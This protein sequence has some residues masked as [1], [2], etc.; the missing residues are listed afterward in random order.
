MKHLASFIC[1][2]FIFSNITAFAQIEKL[3]K[4]QDKL[5]NTKIHDIYQDN[6]GFIWISTENGLS[7][8]DG[9]NFH[10][11]KHEENNPNSI[12]SN[13]VLSATEDSEGNMWVGTRDGLQILEV[14]YN[15]FSTFPLQ[16]IDPSGNSHYSICEMI[17]TKLPDEK[18]ELIVSSR[19]NGL[20]IIDIKELKINKEKQETIND[21]LKSKRIQK[22]LLD[23]KQRLWISYA[24]G[25]LNVCDAVSGLI[26][27]VIENK[28]PKTETVFSYI[29]E[30]PISGN[31]IFSTFDQGLFVYEEKSRTFRAFKDKRLMNY[32]ILTLLYGELPYIN[33][34]RTMIIGTDNYGFK[35]VDL[36]SEELIDIPLSKSRHHTSHWKVSSLLM[37]KQENIWAGAYQTGLFL[38]PKPMYNFE[39]ACFNS[40][41]IEGENSSCITSIIED[42]E[43]EVLWIGSDGSGLFKMDRSAYY[44]VF[45]KENSNL[46]DNSIMSL[47]IDKRGDLWIASFHG[48][49]SKRVNDN[50][51]KKL[52]LDGKIE[53]VQLTSLQYDSSRDLM[54]V[55]TNGHGLIILDAEKEEVIR[56]ISDKINK[57]IGS[58]TLAEDNSVWIGTANGL[59]NYFYD[60]DE[61]YRHSISNNEKEEKINTVKSRRNGNILVGTDYGLIEYTPQNKNRHDITDGNS[62][63]DISVMGILESNDEII[64]LSTQDGLVKYNPADSSYFNYSLADGLQ[65]NQF[66]LNAAYKGDNGIMYFGGVGGLSFFNQNLDNNYHH[67]LP[68]IYF[69]ELY[70]NGS[71]INYDSHIDSKILDKHI[72]EATIINLPYA[73]NS[74][75][76]RYTVPEFT[77]PTRI[78]YS[79]RLLGA[80]GKWINSG[81]SRS[82]TFAKLPAGQ[83]TLQIRANLYGNESNYTQRD[84]LIKIAPPAYLSVWAFL[85]YIIIIAILSLLIYDI[86]KVGKNRKSKRLQ[87]EL[88][89]QKVKL[90][91]E[92]SYEIKTPLSIAIKELEKIKTESDSKTINKAYKE[93]YKNSIRAKQALGQILN[94]NKEMQNETPNFQETE[95]NGFI[96][97]IIK[98]FDNIAEARNIKLEL[99][100]SNDAINVW[101]DHDILDSIIFYMIN[102]AFEQI[103]DESRISIDISE[104][105]HNNG[106]LNRNVNKYIKINF[107]CHDI[108]YEESFFNKILEQMYESDLQDDEPKESARF[109]IIRKS[110]ER[111]HGRMWAEN[112]PEDGLVFIIFIPIG[113]NHLNLG[114]IDSDSK[115]ITEIKPIASANKDNNEDN[116]VADYDLRKLKEDYLNEKKLM[117]FTGADGVF[118]RK[119]YNYII[120]NIANPSLSVEDLGKHIGISRVHLNRKLKNLLEL[121]PN[122][123]IKSIRMRTSVRLLMQEKENIADIANKVGFSTHSYFSSSFK[124]HFGISPKDF[125]IKYNDP[126]RIEDYL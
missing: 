38:I 113:R 55:G 114:Q 124:E 24:D 121:S 3:Y 104:P 107:R 44:E 92:M 2:F 85:F 119:C 110:I 35:L 12:A 21:N 54:Y 95:I 99:I 81:T 87:A 5:S 6:L 15:R 41:L 11:F 19:G 116:E 63:S 72:T 29:E 51:F 100:A 125:I 34:E 98:S 76:I 66:Q 33:K 46:H 52:N 17:E 25:G 14:A 32:P 109:R 117:G 89:E 88:N 102:K 27:N 13:V 8:F 118:L 71:L 120:E 77:N 83:Y 47:S 18:K 56:I 96:R 40:D 22:I 53:G 94:M 48:G 58:I 103:P 97:S 78:N 122:E 62:L 84:I 9:H 115:L 28:I 39:Y 59:Y 93:I 50:S 86:I 4:S 31:I 123:L 37:D 42:T 45:N 108:K 10:T 74:F 67:D 36:D 91:T 80:D 90:Y 7:R 30:D 43:N 68:P 69:T 49:L 105:I 26:L 20:Y 61:I 65:D 75:T 16:K 111:L 79:Y 64:W 70:V 106:F 1:L 60:S 82:V 101:I 112:N 126:E 73:N 23:S 57:W